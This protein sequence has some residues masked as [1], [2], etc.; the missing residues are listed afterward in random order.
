MI[1]MECAPPVQEKNLVSICSVIRN[2]TYPQTI[3]LGSVDCPRHAW[4]L[5][6]WAKRS[7]DRWVLPKRWLTSR[8]GFPELSVV[9]N[10]KLAEKY[11]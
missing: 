4:G 7:L 10:E 9:A 8:H 2:Q 11:S 5:D 1:K 6:S 3:D